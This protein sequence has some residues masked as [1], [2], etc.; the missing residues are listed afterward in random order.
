MAR[1]D[2]IPL[3]RPHG[4]RPCAAA[5]YRRAEEVRSRV[6]ACCVDVVV[7]GE[8]AHVG[9]ESKLASREM[10]APVR[11]LQAAEWLTD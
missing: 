7:L 1:H 8:V 4:A 11:I 5:V 6:E 2:D 10:Q 3:M 9:R